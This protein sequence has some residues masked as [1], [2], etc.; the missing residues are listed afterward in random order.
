[1]PS[2]KLQPRALVARCFGSTEIGIV[3]RESRS[4]FTRSRSGTQARGGCGLAEP[5][6]GRG[7]TKK[8]KGGRASAAH[9][10]P[11]LE[12]LFESALAKLVQETGAAASTAWLLVRGRPT[13][14][15]HGD[16]PEDP[17]S[18]AALRALS[19]HGEPV[20]LREPTVPT[21]LADYGRKC[22]FEAAAPLMTPV[23]DLPMEVRDPRK[24]GTKSGGKSR[25][26]TSDSGEALGAIFLRSPVRPRTLAILGQLVERLA[27]PAATAITIARLG[28]V[29]DELARMTRLATLGD[30]LAETVHEI[31]NPLVSV[32]TFLQLLPENLDDPDFHTNFRGQVVD[33][34][35]RMERL[36]DGVLEQAR[37]GG[38]AED[39]PSDACVGTVLQ[40]ISRLLE[41]RAQ[42]KQLRLVVDVGADLPRA[43]IEE[44]PLRQV[45]LNLTLNA[46]EASPEGGCVRLTARE[47]KGRLALTIDDEGPGVPENE[48]SRLFEPFFSTRAERPVGLGLA[49]CRRLVSGAGGE[50]SVQAAPGEA[51]GARFQ[52]LLSGAPEA[53]TPT[54]GQSETQAPGRSASQTASRA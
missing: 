42:E 4:V 52:V 33:E 3:R 40:S 27:T 50:I 38:S 18:A 17:P 34:V 44:D 10:F 16:A 19:D 13:R 31:R 24:G 6:L 43:S 7:Q 49:V 51:G 36:L 26:G 2:S 46:F 8:R 22:G 14:I 32:K 23:S 12:A 28:R 53:P 30:L 21:A 39:G 11:E 20:D 48:R 37:P 1:M 25:N 54:Q 47:R 9:A 29:E 45:V 5:G 41:K 35:R 15:A